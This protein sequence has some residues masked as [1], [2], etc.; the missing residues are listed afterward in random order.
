MTDLNQPVK[1]CGRNDSFTLLSGREVIDLR[2]LT[3]DPDRTGTQ[4]NLSNNGRELNGCWTML[5]APRGNQVSLAKRSETRL[6][7]Y[8]A[9]G[10]RKSSMATR[11]R[12]PQLATF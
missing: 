12:T 1:V 11:E 5:W 9:D 2:W 10:I 8:Q 6:L 3:D 4:E 7:P